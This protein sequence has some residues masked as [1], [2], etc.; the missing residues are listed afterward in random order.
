MMPLLNTRLSVQ[1]NN[2][3]DKLEN[4]NYFTPNR[5]QKPNR[6]F[7]AS[8]QSQGAVNGSFQEKQSVRSRLS[9]V[10]GSTRHLGDIISNGAFNG[11]NFD[12]NS[13]HNEVQIHEKKGSHK[14]VIQEQTNFNE[15]SV[16]FKS[17]ENSKHYLKRV[18]VIP[19]HNMRDLQQVSQ[20]IQ[21]IPVS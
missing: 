21:A 1:S 19:Y 18:P 5:G 14:N 16:D 17:E 20:P 4:Q 8:V 10:G 15:E 11:S 13:G 7:G 6:L 3:I 2:S 12:G 9:H